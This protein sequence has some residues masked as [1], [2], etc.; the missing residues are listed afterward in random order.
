MGE[1]VYDFA[2]KLMELRDMNR[3]DGD[4][5]T[6]MDV[7]ATLIEMAFEHHIPDLMYA[8]LRAL[9]DED[10]HSLSS[11]LIGMFAMSANSLSKRYG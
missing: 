1:L 6:V 3:S 4:E 9:S 7:M 8:P 2:G 5:S 10:I 11:R